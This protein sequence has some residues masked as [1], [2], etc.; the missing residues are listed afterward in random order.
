MP[1]IDTLVHAR[2][3]HSGAILTLLFVVLTFAGPLSALPQAAEPAPPATPP[4]DPPPP[5]AAVEPLADLGTLVRGDVVV[6]EFVLRNSGTEPL[7]IERVGGSCTCTKVTFGGAVAPGGEGKLRVELDSSII[8]GTVTV[9]VDAWVKGY[10]TAV[11]VALKVNV[12]AK[13]LAKPGHARWIYVQHE[14]EGTLGQTVY[15]ADGSDFKILAVESPMPAITV[16]H[17]EAKPEERVAGFGGSQWRVEPTLDSAAPVGAITGFIAVR[18][19]HPLQKVIRIPVSGFVRPT[20]LIN[21]ERSD[22]GTLALSGPRHAIYQVRNFATESIAVTGAETDV[23]G[24]TARIEPVEK[25]RTYKVVLVLDPVSMKEGPFAGK[26]SL[27]TDSVKVPTLTVE[28]SGS[29]VRQAAGTK[30]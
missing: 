28:L 16:T 23:P 6:H 17:R 22:F 12:V 1:S 4:A 13:L 19:T 11:R 2:R 15:A 18:T 8:N 25:G 3:R 26:L 21:P 27:K 10:S 9:T 30:E 20:V 24:I 5:L 7:T 29:L 14:R